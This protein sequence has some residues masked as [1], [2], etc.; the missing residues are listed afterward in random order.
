LS[1]VFSAGRIGA[2]E[3]ANRLV[4][5]ATGERMC[6]PTGRV[7][8]LLVEF[9]ARLAEG[10]VGL[11]VTGHSFV[12]ADGKA[13][14][15][16][17]GVHSDAM[18]PGLRQLV[19]AVH[20]RG[21]RIVCQLNHAGRQTRPELTGGKRPIAPSAVTDRATGITPRALAAAEI[22]P[23]IEC[24]VEAARRCRDAGFDGVQLHCAHGYLM[25]EFISPYTNRREDAWGGSL[26]ARARFPLEVLR[27]IRAALGREFP[28]LVKL[29]A[30]DFIEGGLT[31]GESCRI[32]A[33]L[34]K[35]GID[36]I[37]ISAGMAETVDKI[38][39]KNVAGPEQEAYFL[40]YARE[41][42]RWVSVP[43]IL[44][45]GLRSLG[46]MELVLQSG[47][48]DFVSLSRPLIREPELPRKLR[49]GA[50][51]RAAC[52]SCNCCGPDPEGRLACTLDL[53]L[54]KRQ[55]EP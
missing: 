28:V 38:V 54:A 14:E 13:S 3:L 33:M 45:G 16:M 22:E 19:E 1:A 6:R 27:R 49:D 43:L 32:A 55:A 46:V 53:Q 31:L 4:R 30:E 23:L 34:E 15:G 17:M 11:I 48:A 47:A 37:E 20:A 39:R 25:S 9:Y 7:T 18:L 5:S 21:G 40:P 50:A 29:N 24:Y 41:F 42:R 51:T 2:L 12:R 35:E 52:V 44:V 8:P 26:E 10:G 36:A